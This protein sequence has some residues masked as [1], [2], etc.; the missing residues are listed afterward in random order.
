MAFRPDQT[1]THRTR[2]VV[3][4]ENKLRL[5]HRAP[6]LARVSV[7][8]GCVSQRIHGTPFFTLSYPL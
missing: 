6:P 2:I 3:T 4:V 7:T 1:T 8:V 5:E